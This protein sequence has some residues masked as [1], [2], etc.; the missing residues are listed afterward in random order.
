MKID[1]MP[2]RL[3]ASMLELPIASKLFGHCA[4]LCGTHHAFMPVAIEVASFTLFK[5]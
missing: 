3:N 5:A 1:V 4:E 2:G